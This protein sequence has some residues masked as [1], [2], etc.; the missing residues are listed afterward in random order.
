MKRQI[1]AL[2]TYCRNEKQN[3]SVLPCVSLSSLRL[4]WGDF[5]NHDAGHGVPSGVSIRTR[6]LPHA[7]SNID[8]HSHGSFWDSLAISSN[9]SCSMYVGVCVLMVLINVD[10]TINGHGFATFY[11]VEGK[12]PASA[13]IQA[14][15]NSEIT[16]KLCF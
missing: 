2:Y 16:V 10:E 14:V 5:L 12:I 11:T 4:R 13:A 8:S 6:F 1:L 15:S 3:R 9:L 7:V